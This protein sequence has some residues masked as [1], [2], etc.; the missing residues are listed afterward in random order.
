MPRCSVCAHPDLAE[1]DAALVEGQSSQQIVAHYGSLSRPAVQR[2]RESHLPEKLVRAQRIRD[3]TQ[4]DELLGRVLRREQRGND[5]YDAAWAWH[6]RAL[7]A[8][9]ADV[10]LRA[11]AEA[12]R[13]LGELR[14]TAALLF[15]RRDI[16]DL[17]ERLD[18][19]EE[20]NEKDK[21]Q[22]GRGYGSF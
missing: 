12:R 4:G 22:K 21:R 8:N 11:I 19:L 20:Q 2:H 17:E 13:V 10:S 9:D 7:A 14:Q 6:Q 16:R 15:G 18:A 3:L 1:I 5:L